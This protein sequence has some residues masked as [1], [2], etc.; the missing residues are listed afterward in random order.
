MERVRRDDGRRAELGHRGRGSARERWSRRAHLR[1]YLGLVRGLLAG[2][3]A[4][5]S[6]VARPGRAGAAA[7]PEARPRPRRRSPRGED[8]AHRGGRARG[9]GARDPSPRLR[10]PARCRSG[11]RGGSGR[12]RRL[13]PVSGLLVGGDDAGAGQRG[14]PRRAHAAGHPLRA[15]RPRP[16]GGLSRLLREAGGAARS[17]TR[18]PFARSRARR[19]APSW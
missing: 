10:G 8:R 3:D 1:A 9:G 18:T 4:R 7:G 11:G 14:R 13:L 6:A 19:D 15:R 2:E 5:P 12:H 17:R 16:P